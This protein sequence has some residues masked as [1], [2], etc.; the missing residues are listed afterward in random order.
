M[1]WEDST[2]TSSFFFSPLARLAM[3]TVSRCSLHNWDTV[4]YLGLFKGC[5]VVIRKAGEIIPELVKCTE[6]GRS[7][8]DY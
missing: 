2:A 7:K 3:T 1:A 6:T 5:H 4:E 8:D